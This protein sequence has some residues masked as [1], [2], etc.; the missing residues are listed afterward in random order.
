M[1]TRHILAF[2]GSLVAAIALSLGLQFLS[3]APVTA[4]N[5]AL[6][7]SAAAS[8]QDALEDIKPLFET[9]QPR[10]TISYNFGSSGSLQQQIE[11]GAPADIFISAAATQM[12]ALAE[13]DLLLPDTRQD[14]LSNRL[15]L[16][17]PQDST[18]N[19]TGFRQLT[20]P[21]VQRI[22]VGEFRSVPAGTYAQQ[23]FTNLG[24]LEQVQPKL[25]FANNVRGVLA[26][27][28]SGN[29]DAGIVYTTDA[30]L[31]D[32]VTQVAT[33]P[34]DLHNPIVYPIAVIKTSR[35]PVASRAFI[36]FLNSPAAEEIFEKYGF[37]T[38]E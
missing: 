33:A 7:V 16:I 34:E 10:T 19:L 36:D 38:L 6:L 28:E 1:K 30:R 31:S 15:V 14:L 21:Q 4:Q 18:L 8:L 9:A 26:A 2:V 22:S 11:Q 13:A 32:K 27:V 23:V 12:D 3:P 17:V 24:I 35:Y 29:V 25:V 5:T 20:E 37:I